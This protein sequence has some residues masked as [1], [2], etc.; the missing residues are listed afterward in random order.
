MSASH[1]VR[2]AL[3]NFWERHG[4]SAHWEKNAVYE[5]AT[6]FGFL[7]RL[8]AEEETGLIRVCAALCPEAPE[9]RREA[10]HAVLLE[11]N[12]ADR[13]VFGGSLALDPETLEI[14]YQRA[15]DSRQG[16]AGGFFR[17]FIAFTEA[18]SGLQAAVAALISDEDD[19][20]IPSGLR[21]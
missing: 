9:E 1:I 6:D 5:I 20:L 2:D 7:V 18:A 17:F 15:Y 11:A 21:L 4:L 8:A 12:L 13:L 14:V 16:G 3:E 19:A 10:V